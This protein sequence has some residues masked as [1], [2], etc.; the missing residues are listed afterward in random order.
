MKNKRIGRLVGIMSMTLTLA[1]GLG[2]LI[3]NGNVKS[4]ALCAEQASE[5][6]EVIADDSQM[7]EELNTELLKLNTN[8]IFSISCKSSASNGVST[9]IPFQF[10]LFEITSAIF[11]ALP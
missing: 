4:N 10:N 2:I 7:K 6:V 9:L 5:V 8:T 3:G 11:F 1:L